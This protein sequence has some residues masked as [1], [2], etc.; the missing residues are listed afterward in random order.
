MLL[1]LM[2]L[3]KLTECLSVSTEYL[4]KFVKEDETE[5]LKVKVTD[6]KLKEPK[7]YLQV[8]KD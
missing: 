3:L 6:Y 2:P 8:A 5:L 1:L 4:L 7:S